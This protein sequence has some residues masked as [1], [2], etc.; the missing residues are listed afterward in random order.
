L[1]ELEKKGKKSV[2]TVIN[3]FEVNNN[4]DKRFIA[5]VKKNA[6]KETA[7]Q[8]RISVGTWTERVCS[9]ATGESTGIDREVNKHAVSNSEIEYRN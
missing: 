4:T 6:N 3:K 8:R 1:C 7:F 9:V 2:E 5:K